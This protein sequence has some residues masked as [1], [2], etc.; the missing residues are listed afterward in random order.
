MADKKT[1]HVR[2]VIVIDDMEMESVGNDDLDLNEVVS[3]DINTEEHIIDVTDIEVSDITLSDVTTPQVTFDK[4][5]IKELEHVLFMQEE[6]DET[7]EDAY[8]KSY[9]LLEKLIT[10]VDID[11]IDENA[12]NV[13]KLNSD[14][15]EIS[16]SDICFNMEEHIKSNTIDITNKEIIYLSNVINNLN[17]DYQNV[18]FNK[19]KHIYIKFDTGF[20]SIQIKEIILYNL[21]TLKTTFR[22]V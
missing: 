19:L 13:F 21:I 11:E 22:V 1:E 6:D 17:R 3:E 9:K 14:K 4:I 7:L 15:T 20:D 10:N 2:E 5:N 8:K 12:K 16:Y 18:P